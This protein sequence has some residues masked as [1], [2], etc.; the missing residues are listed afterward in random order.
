MSSFLTRQEMRNC[1]FRRK[2]ANENKQ[3]K[4]TNTLISNSY[5]IRQSFQGYRCESGIVICQLEITLRVHL[6]K[7]LDKYS[8]T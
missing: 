6:K 2:T 1:H 5:L 7:K 3:F 8:E 4:E